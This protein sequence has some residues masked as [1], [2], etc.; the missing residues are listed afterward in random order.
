MRSLNFY[1]FVDE[2]STVSE[3]FVG[4]PSIFCHGSRSKYIVKKRKTKHDN[5]AKAVLAGGVTSQ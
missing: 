2:M 4:V 1:T 5:L 3:Y